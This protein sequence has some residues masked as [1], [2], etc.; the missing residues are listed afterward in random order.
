MFVSSKFFLG[1]FLQRFGGL[2]NLGVFGGIYHCLLSIFIVFEFY[3][4]P[5]LSI[6][7]RGDCCILSFLDIRRY[8]LYQ[9]PP[10]ILILQLYNLDYLDLLGVLGAFLRLI[11]TLKVGTDFSEIHIEAF[12]SYIWLATCI[13]SGHARLSEGVTAR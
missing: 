8:S 13:N 5:S 7:Y 9:G 6:H 3:N 4:I 2:T 10:Y 12:K 11:V 1:L